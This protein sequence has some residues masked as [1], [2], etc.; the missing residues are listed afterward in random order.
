MATCKN[1]LSYKACK[2]LWECF[3]KSED[4]SELYSGCAEKCDFFKN[5]ARY[6]EIPCEVGDIV[7]KD[8]L[9]YKCYRMDRYACEGKDPYWRFWASPLNNTDEDDIWFWDSDIAEENIIVLS[10]NETNA[11]LEKGIEI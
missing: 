10:K 3:N 9:L 11:I 4:F 2:H 6:I 8:D 1:C 5:A 7:K